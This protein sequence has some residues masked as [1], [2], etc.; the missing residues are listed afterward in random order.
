M[1][2][3]S[4]LHKILGAKIELLMEFGFNVFKR[5]IYFQ[6]FKTYYNIDGDVLTRT[7]IEGGR[8]ICNKIR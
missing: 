5:M 4:N 3:N 1:I 7:S 2:P 8:Q 6:V